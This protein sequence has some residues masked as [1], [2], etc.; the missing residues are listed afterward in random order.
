MAQ[1]SESKLIINNQLSRCNNLVELGSQ[2]KNSR[3]N[4]TMLSSGKICI[5]VKEEQE[6]NSQL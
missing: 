1:I 5:A 3:L 4:M 2:V 6:E